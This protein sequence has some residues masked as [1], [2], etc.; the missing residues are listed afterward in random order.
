MLYAE[1]STFASADR[2]VEL[3]LNHVPGIYPSTLRYTRPAF[4]LQHGRG[5]GVYHP[6]YMHVAVGE[7]P[8]DLAAED[9]LA[10]AEVIR[11]RLM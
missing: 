10:H 2:P 7:S 8:R 1:I 9:A 4:K 6:L 3:R 5:R 11:R